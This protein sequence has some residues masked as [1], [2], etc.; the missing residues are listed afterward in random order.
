MM[1]SILKATDEINGIFSYNI[2][3]FNEVITV[4]VKL[5]PD[6]YVVEGAIF[7]VIKKGIDLKE[8]GMENIAKQELNYI[9]P[10]IVIS[11]K[12]A[13]DE[14]LSKTLQHTYM[15]RDFYMDDINT[16]IINNFI[17]DIIYVEGMQKKRFKEIKKNKKTFFGYIVSLFKGK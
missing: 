13:F 11:G 9:V 3:G 7:S 8:F 12:S 14:A 1:K 2:N 15:F 6:S 10:S 17:N 4:R 16:N 5:D